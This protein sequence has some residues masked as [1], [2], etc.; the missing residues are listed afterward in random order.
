MH[1]LQSEPEQL[2][3][4]HNV[5]APVAWPGAKLEPSDQAPEP[6]P[7]PT[8]VQESRN[9]CEL[10]EAL[11]QRHRTH[12]RFQVTDILYNILLGHR[13]GGRAVLFKPSW[14][15]EEGEVI[16]VAAR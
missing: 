11:G 14:V 10:A 12:A 15:C 13:G 8:R 5:I 1:Q 4:L 3:D 16:G 7:V 9:P 2:S 6:M